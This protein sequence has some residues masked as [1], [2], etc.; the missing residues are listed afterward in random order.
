MINTSF[1][2][3]AL[4]AASLCVASMLVHAATPIPGLTPVDIRGLWFPKSEAGSAKCANYLG[5]QPVEPD[6]GALVINE[7]QMVRWVQ[8]GQSA[9]I[10]VT[11][12]Q[13]R[14]RN[15]W[16]IQG[17]LDAPPY[18]APKVLETYVFEVRQDDLHWSS[19]REGARLSE[20]VETS[21]FARCG[22]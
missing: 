2:F 12:V 7:R 3:K 18:E 5:R 10:F 11:D 14:R 1:L 6:V 16:R 13:P 17:L 20:R 21:V 8:P 4:S 9:T 22:Y 19:R 15:T